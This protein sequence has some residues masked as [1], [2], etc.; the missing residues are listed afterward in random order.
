M[1][2]QNIPSWAIKGTLVGLIVIIFILLIKWISERYRRR[3]VIKTPLS[4][5]DRMSGTDFENYLAELYRAN[6]YKVTQVGGSGDYGADLIL[7]RSNRT[8]IVQ[9]KRYSDKVS[10]PAVQQVFTAKYFYDADDCIVVT[11]SYFTRN[12]RTL[13]AKVG[14][15]LVDREALTKYISNLSR[16]G[17]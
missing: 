11:N 9:A 16:K 1:F 10:L 12:A 15:G 14:V 8:T 17:A 4:K 7:K 2:P 13:A 6:G 3:V 5:I